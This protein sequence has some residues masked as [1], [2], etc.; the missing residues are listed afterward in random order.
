ST[1]GGPPVPGRETVA[2]LG[3]GFMGAAM[4]RRL[5]GAGFAL[6]AWN[7]TRER[8]EPLAEAGAVVCASPA[9]AASGAGIL[10]TSLADGDAVA[11]AVEG[12]EGGLAG[13]APG[14][15]WLEVSTI[16]VDETDR[17]AALAAK[18]GV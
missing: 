6:R 13:L 10:L 8:A 11:A 9:E 3:T 7:R 16:G 18:A 14:S 1:R 15:V 2:L 4:G 17:F 12:P 5:L